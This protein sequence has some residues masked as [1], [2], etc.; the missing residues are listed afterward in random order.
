MISRLFLRRNIIN[1]LDVP[2]YVIQVDSLYFQARESGISYA[3][4][5]KEP[6][7]NLQTGKALHPDF[8]THWGVRGKFGVDVGHDCWKIWIQYLHY[9]ARV[10]EEKSSAFYLPSWGHPQ[11]VG[12]G[13]ADSVR[14]RWRLHL[15][16]GDLLLSRSWDFSECIDF[17]PFW[18]LRGACVRFKSRVNYRGGTLF[19]GEEDDLS[20]KNK[21][22]GIGPEIGTEALWHFGCGFGLYSRIGGSLLFG[23]F[24]IHQDENLTGEKDGIKFHNCFW[25]TQFLLDMALG[26]EYRT[27][28]KERRIE[29]FGRIS[30]DL[31]LFFG[32]N[33]S[34]RFVSSEM[35]G[36][37]VTNQGDLSLQGLTISLGIG[38]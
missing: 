28:S 20:M 22:F 33:Q 30:W 23:E 6:E 19:P 5:Q 9:H 31:F 24:Y 7:N 26:L 12:N 29:F 32:Q 25:Q 8:K 15:G 3:I 38:F 10:T 34:V 36:K 21:F 1:M 18:G 2:A 11:R 17:L 37:F 13:Y 16:I 4:E 35:P 27:C 14:S